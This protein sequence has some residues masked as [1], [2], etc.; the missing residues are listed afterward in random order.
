MLTEIPEDGI[1]LGE[2]IRPSELGDRKMVVG[3]VAT[4]LADPE[5]W[6]NYENDRLYEAD[7]RFREW[8]EEMRK[9]PKWRAPNTKMRRY[10]FSKLFYLVTGERYEQGKHSMWVIPF[11]KVFRN[12]STRIMRAGTVD[13]KFRSKTIYV[14]SAAALDRPPLSV[15]LRIPWLMEHNIAIDERT[16]KNPDR[17][18][19]RPGHATNPR[20]DANMQRR[21]E[22]AK[23]RYNERYRDRSH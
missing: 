2:D 7:K 3:P 10:T 6:R 12:Y 4:W 19:L 22:E 18:L 1:R 8:V 20:T 16:M 5:V 14:I 15:R 9:D 13:G 23:R 21:S 17:K 11:S